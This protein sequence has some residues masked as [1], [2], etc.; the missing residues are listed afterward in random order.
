MGVVKPFVLVM[1]AANIL[2]IPFCALFIV[3]LRLGA[4]GAAI[5]L[6]LMGINL[7]G[8]CLVYIVRSGVYKGGVRFGIA[9]RNGRYF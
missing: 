1:L 9:R 6:V 8:F 4:D 5:C 2:N 3:H 7:A